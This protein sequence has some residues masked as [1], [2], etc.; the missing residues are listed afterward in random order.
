[1]TTSEPRPDDRLGGRAISEILGIKRNSW[2]T[3]VKHRMTPTPDGRDEISGWPWWY[4]KTIEEWKATRPGRGYRSDLGEK[5]YKPE[6]RR[7]R[8]HA[9]ATA[10]P[11]D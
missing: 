9:K 2:N 10:T 4:R 8:E 7:A 5:G 11:T 6:G 3:M 1:M